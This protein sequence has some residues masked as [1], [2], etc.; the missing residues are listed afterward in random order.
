MRVYIGGSISSDKNY[1][2]KFKKCEKA[3]RKHYPDW[4]IFNPAEIEVKNWDWAD[5]MLFDLQQ[6]NKCDAI[7]CIEDGMKE[8]SYGIAIEKLWCG[9]TNKKI[10]FYY[11]KLDKLMIYELDRFNP[12]S[13]SE[14]L[15]N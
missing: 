11:T 9:R 13:W 14:A 3:V 2:K 4:E 5:Y 6:L 10:G 7:I 15:N 12:W 8:F 1:K